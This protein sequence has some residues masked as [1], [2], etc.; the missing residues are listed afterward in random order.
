LG[1]KHPPRDC[2]RW[3]RHI[4]SVRPFSPWRDERAI[5]PDKSSKEATKGVV[6]GVEHSG[7]VF[8]DDDAFGISAFNSNSV[9]CVGEFTER[10]GKLSTGVS[11]G[12][13]KASNAECLA[14]RSAYQ[15][16]GSENRARADLVCDLGHVA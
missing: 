13:A 11:K 3:S 14:R 9:N 12:F 5:F 4:T 2:S 10:K 16:I 6:L 8:P 7:D 15:H 1:I